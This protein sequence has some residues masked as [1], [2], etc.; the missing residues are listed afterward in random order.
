MQKPTYIFY[1]GKKSY[2]VKR[3]ERLLHQQAEEGD[4][5]VADIRVIIGQRS[6][7]DDLFATLT[8]R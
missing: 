5:G 7:D 1:S 6:A 3:L 2:T 8:A 4:T